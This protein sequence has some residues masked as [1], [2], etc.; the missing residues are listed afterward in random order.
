VLYQ[1]DDY[2]KDYVKAC[3]PGSADKAK[4]ILIEASYELSDPT[5]DS[6]IVQLQGRRHR[7]HDRAVLRQ[8]S[9]QS[10]RKVHELAGTR[11]MSSAL[12]P[13]CRTVLKPA[14]LDASK[15]W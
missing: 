14:G 4:Q 13:I 2:G 1:N 5:I 12:R 9:A 3:A 15:G 8:G 10:I 11:C 6:Q 7:H